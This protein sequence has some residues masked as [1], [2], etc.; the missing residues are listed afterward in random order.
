MRELPASE[1]YKHK[2]RLDGLQ[3]FCKSCQC[4]SVRASTYGITVEEAEAY[5]QIP[6][7]QICNEKFL[8]DSD[9]HFDHCHQHG[10]IR[11]VLCGPCN[12]S[13]AGTAAQCIVRNE[14]ANDY[15]LRDMEVRLEPARAG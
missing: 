8:V 5:L 14:R 4:I 15:L 12:R 13:L 2:S 6:S 7:C 11:G 9:V 1:F 10:H 3:T